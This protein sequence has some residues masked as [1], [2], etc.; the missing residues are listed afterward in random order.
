MKED[1]LSPKFLKN[2]LIR[3]LFLILFNLACMVPGPK[4]FGLYTTHN[5][6]YGDE[7][8]SNES[9]VRILSWNIAMLPA[10]DFV[11]SGVN[12]AE[13]IGSAL[14]K[15]DYDMIVFQEAFSSAARQTIYKKIR[16]LYPYAYGPAN[17]GISMK[18]NS[19]V[20]IV[21]QVP[22]KIIKEYKYSGCQ[23]FDCLSRK[24]AI[25]LEG[26]FQGQQFQVIGTHLE[27][28]D[29]DLWVREK[30][31]QELFDSIIS[32]YSNR[33][34]PQ[35]ICGDFNI[36]RDLSEQYMNMLKILQCDDGNL[37]GNERITFGFPLNAD[38]TVVL[39]KPRQLDYILTKNSGILGLISRKVS[40]IKESFATGTG[41]LS[42]HYGIEAIIQFR[43]TGQNLVS[44]Q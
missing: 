16:K 37:L 6:L 20:W 22:L 4:L 9:Q 34:I 30:Q 32:P 27:S 15:Q 35:I 14:Q 29:S 18:I 10:L 43:L 2:R 21:S 38:T 31:L 13:G 24:G 19:G 39:E 42:D 5:Q 12:R 3:S 17:A 26:T 40:V 25:L 28:D 44:L 33:E 8:K 1:H 23:G 7:P 41:H 11:Q 36:D